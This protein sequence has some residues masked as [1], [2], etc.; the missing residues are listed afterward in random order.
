[1]ARAFEK[2][3]TGA[4]ILLKEVPDAEARF[5]VAEMDGRVVSIEE[6]PKKPKSNYAVTGI[7]MYDGGVFEKVKS[8]YPAGAVNSKSPTSTTLIFARAA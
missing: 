5:G 4:R 7:Y 8:W 2:Q 3:P 6:K 1:M